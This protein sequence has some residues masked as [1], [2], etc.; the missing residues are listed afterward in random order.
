METSVPEKLLPCPFCG[1]QPEVTLLPDPDKGDFWT[2]RCC[3]V[4]DFDTWNEDKK[5]SLKIGIKEII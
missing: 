1:K 5:N 4:D 3:K 2:I